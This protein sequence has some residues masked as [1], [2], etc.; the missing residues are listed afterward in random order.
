MKFREV[1][2]GYLIRLER[3]D[4]VVATLTD[5]VR[6]HKIPA[7]FITGMGA[8]RM[9]TLGIYDTEKH[10]YVKK[11]FPQDLEV[12]NLTA[13]ISYL[14]DDEPFVHC[15]IIV[16]D[17]TLNAFTGHL[18]EG[19]VSVTLEIFLKTFKEKLMRK[20]EPGTAFKF[21]QL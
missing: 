7:G 1:E 21:W 18:F 4:E 14:D 3:G 10:E 20:E 8:V 9:A 19:T 6:Q 12:G 17:V 15:H 13:N 5:F 11:Y 2:D 16:S